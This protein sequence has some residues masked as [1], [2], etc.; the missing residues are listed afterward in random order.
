MQM[1][2]TPIQQLVGDGQ[3][4]AR[5]VCWRI[6]DGM[7]LIKEQALGARWRWYDADS[8]RYN[9]LGDGAV[10][11]PALR[12]KLEADLAGDKTLKIGCIGSDADGDAERP[13]PR[14]QARCM[15]EREREQSTVLIVGSDKGRA[16]IGDL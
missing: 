10:V 3:I 6:V 11:E 9:Q 4:V 8:E 16:W 12:L 7:S 15:L 1:I 5:E 14:P 2:T 13:T